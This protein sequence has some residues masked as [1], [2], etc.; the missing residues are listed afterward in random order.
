MQ[1]ASRVASASVGFLGGSA[2][3]GPDGEL[4]LNLDG[5]EVSLNQDLLPLADEVATAELTGPLASEV[6]VLAFGTFV[7]SV[8]RNGKFKRLHQIGGCGRKPGVDYAC[9]TALGMEAP[10]ASS[11]TAKC[12]GCFGARGSHF[13][14]HAEASESS[15]SSSEP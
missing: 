4:Q 13:V 3:G 5:N 8:Q 7:V 14:P 9:F 15:A 11:Y 6:P 1:Q 10:D 2:L 12:K